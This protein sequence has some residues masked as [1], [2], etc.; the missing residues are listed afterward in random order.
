MFGGLT[1]ALIVGGIVMVVFGALFIYIK[2]RSSS[3]SEEED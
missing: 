3:A 1:N 2:S